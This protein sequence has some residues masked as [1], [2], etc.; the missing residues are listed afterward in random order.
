M[1]Y[2]LKITARSEMGYRFMLNDIY[3]T[4]TNRRLVIY[5]FRKPNLC[6]IGSKKIC[7]LARQKIRNRIF[8]NHKTFRV[9]GQTQI[10][11][12]FPDSGPVY[13]VTI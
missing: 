11:I 9:A 12:V 13:A 8:V 5:K 10:T 6:S 1:F 7:T 4:S 2:M 3:K